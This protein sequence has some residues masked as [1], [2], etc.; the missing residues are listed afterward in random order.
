MG[1]GSESGE[2]ER[3]KERE[4]EKWS[5]YFDPHM[6]G[7][8]LSTLHALSHLIL[9]RALKGKYYYCATHLLRKLQRSNNFPVSPARRK[10][11]Y[12]EIARGLNK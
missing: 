9:P 12:S 8:M 4:E 10:A 7:I 11:K 3:E 2:K 6:P 1:R 5:T